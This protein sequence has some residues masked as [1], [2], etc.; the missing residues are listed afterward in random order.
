[1][2][3]LERAMQEQASD[4]DPNARELRWTIA[5]NF[6]AI[7]MAARQYDRSEKVLTGLLAEIESA[8]PKPNPLLKAWVLN[9]LV[10]LEVRREQYVKALSYSRVEVA[11]LEAL[12]EVRGP[13]LLMARQNLSLTLARLGIYDEAETVM[14]AAIATTFDAASDYQNNSTDLR[15]S[16]A[17]LL[18]QRGRP[19][20][21]A[22]AIREALA[23]IKTSQV[24]GSAR[25]MN[26]RRLLARAY[27][28]LGD[29]GAAVEQYRV[30]ETWIDSGGRGGEALHRIG[31]LT[32][33]V[34]VLLEL[35]DYEEA[36]S[37]LGRAQA[38]LAKAP[39]Q[40]KEQAELLRLSA[41]LKQAGG[42]MPGLLA[43]LSQ[44]AHVL[45]PTYPDVSPEQVELKVLACPADTAAC[46]ALVQSLEDAGRDTDHP[47]LPHDLE[48]RGRL[49]LGARARESSQPASATRL[50][51]SAL[52][53]AV[54]SGSPALLGLAYGL[55]ADVR[56][57]AGRFDEAIF[58]GKLA[59]AEVQRQRARVVALGAA[60]E[61][62]FLERRSEVYRS[63][64]DRLAGQGRI[65]EALAVLR[66]AKRAEQADWGQR[67]AGALD[68]EQ[69]AELLPWSPA[70]RRL[71]QQLAQTLASHQALA[72]EYAR[73]RRLDAARA[74]TA[75]EQARLATLAQQGR[76][77][78][79]RLQAQLDA[80]LQTVAAATAPAPGARQGAAP[81]AVSDAAERAA[82][83]RVRPRE[84]GV[85]HAW[86]M[87]SP[88]GLRS[89]V[90]GRERSWVRARRVAP[91]EVSRDIA[92]WLEVLRR[93]G[94]GAN[95]R[96]EL[97]ARL[98]E[99]IGRLIDEP[100]RQARASRVVL[101]LDG[102]L[103][104][105][106]LAALHDG[107]QYL[108]QKYT[109]LHAAPVLDGAASDGRPAARTAQVGALSLQA[110]GMTEAAAGLPALPGVARELCG[111][112]RGP[113]QGLS[114]DAAATAVSGCADGGTRGQGPVAGEA[115]ANAQF[116]AARLHQALAAPAAAP[117]RLLHI[118]THF[119][120]RPGHVERS[121]LLL[122]DGQ[123]LGLAE[124]ARLD[125]RGQQLVTLSACETGAPAGDATDGRQ[126]DGLAAA[127]L[128]A[129]ARQVLA[130]LWRVDDQATARFMQVF[131]E[132][133]RRAGSPA[134]GTDWAA[135]LQRTQQR[136]LA[137]GGSAARPH[138]W[139]A[140]V[141][142]DA[143][144]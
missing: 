2:A 68:D 125:L 1:M 87:L 95:G 14:R 118:G 8:S 80:L 40:R 38:E 96:D 15:E 37:V 141:L 138:D 116:T 10:N 100:A 93:Q 139:A 121:W 110:F 81:A 30:I 54:R 79:E 55:Q 51:H 78:R 107:R 56:A 69:V 109:L 45:A 77:E 44:A 71:Q 48:A 35:G 9:G 137:G 59:L 66:L 33:F 123:R 92:R 144:R 36:R 13:E 102:P 61:A 5:Q 70:E 111:I 58:F 124:V 97:G 11:W 90:V 34:R 134:Q 17:E 88:Q 39:A 26:S 12:G 99:H 19:L 43:D 23:L 103:R 106:P 101:W 18:L 98:Y 105:L 73:L 122:G 52:V 16:L 129:G 143:R 112:V 31:S 53:A 128:G 115:V 104:H 72:D 27:A 127:V 76:Q 131:Y 47:A 84:A 49:A 108:A 74:I 21:A 140:F 133:S 85:V 130:S 46:A 50:A 113:V 142:M 136:L 60:A 117:S 63:L 83:A 3:E 132:E 126:I 86:L 57:D 67:G 25:E 41:L 64:A 75:D 91:Q 20:E 4:P 24:K 32:G 65:A 82:L 135:A 120:L 7:L 114:T 28:A 119:V 42:D 89:V 94:A 62:H 29:L 22:Q 6:G